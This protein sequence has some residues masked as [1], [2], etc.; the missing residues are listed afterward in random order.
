MKKKSL[1]LLTLFGAASGPALAQSSVT[2]YGV[3]DSNLEYV[4]HYSAIPSS[5]AGFPG[6]SK[7]RFSLDS[8]GLSGSRWGL[9]GTEDLGR[10]IAAVFVL[11]SGFSV[12]DGKSSQG[13][14]LFGRQAYVG[15]QSKEAGQFTFGRQYTTLFQLL[16]SFQPMSFATQYEPTYV[17]TGLNFRSDNM[18]VYNGTFGPVM[19]QLHWTFGNGASSVNPTG[20]GSGEFA[21]Q[22]RRDSGYGAGI[23]YAAGPIGATIVYDQYNP[24]V[25][26]GGGAFNTG[27]VRKAAVAGSYTV[28]PVK[29]MAG[30]RWGQNKNVDGSLALRDDYYWAGANYQATSSLALTLEYVY[31]K[32]KTI[33]SAPSTQPNPWQLA[34]VADYSLSKRTDLYLTTAYARNAG[35]TLDQASVDANATGYGL[36]PAT[37]SML[38]VAAGMRHK[39]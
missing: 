17:L 29:M 20:G 15:L 16:A 19:A 34:F 28:G 4:N 35:L 12:D 11:E 6:T 18:A 13:G 24:G 25:S 8:G 14:R 37:N 9:R 21:G 2:L 31:Q 33:N 22:F 7:S 38:G 39:F 27:T 26:V 30:Y 36:P 1:A 23:A 32:I 3:I 5:Q 10:G